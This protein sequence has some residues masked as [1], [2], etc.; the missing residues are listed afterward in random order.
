MKVCSEA[1]KLIIILALFV[2]INSIQLPQCQTSSFYK[3]LPLVPDESYI[4]DLDS[5]FGGYNLE[6]TV[7]ADASI[8][9]YISLNSKFRKQKEE[10]PDVPMIGLKSSHLTKVGNSWGQQFI[11]LS[12]KGGK[13][14]VHYGILND[15]STVPVINNYITVV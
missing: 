9:K 1:F 2:S 4:M 13:T 8:Q 11:T 3:T 12:Q 10:F 6:Y 14:M 5:F 7:L 15:N